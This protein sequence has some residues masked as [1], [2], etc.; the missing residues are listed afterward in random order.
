MKTTGVT[1]VVLLLM[2]AAFFAGHRWGASD[3][4]ERCINTRNGELHVGGIKGVGFFVCRQAEE[5]E[6]ENM[7]IER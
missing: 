1:I 3:V 6:I 7:K 2:G 4:L 5:Y